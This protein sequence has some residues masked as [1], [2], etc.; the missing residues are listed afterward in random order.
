MYFR[1]CYSSLRGVLTGSFLKSKDP[2]VLI[3][4]TTEKEF[5]SKEICVDLARN[6]HK[7]GIKTGLNQLL[8]GE[9]GD[10]EKSMHTFHFD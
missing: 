9:R 2:G 1:G 3:T 10:S 5:R 6:N 8:P 7:Q 4:V